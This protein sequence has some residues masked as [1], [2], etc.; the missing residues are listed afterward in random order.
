M[1]KFTVTDQILRRYHLGLSSA[2]ESAAVEAWLED[3]EEEVFPSF[4]KE[5][6]EEIEEQLWASIQQ[7]I[8]LKETKKQKL[9]LL[10]NGLVIAASLVVVLVSSLMVYKTVANGDISKAVQ[11]NN[12]N[13]GISKVKN[14]DGL[15]F[16]ALPKGNIQANIS[17]SSGKVTFCDVMLIENNSVKDVSLDFASSCSGTG[18]G[19]KNFVCKRGVTYVALKMSR[20]SPDIIVVDQRYMDDLLPLNVAMQINKDLKSI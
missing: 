9:R 8:I 15:I 12:L 17:H 3:T 4:N 14:I 18:R 16:T 13:G 6:E 20:V 19:P 1:D 7:S 10:R 5:Q 2:E 11:I